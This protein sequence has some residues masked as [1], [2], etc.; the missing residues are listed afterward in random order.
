MEA[1]KKGILGRNTVD[2]M[3]SGTIFGAAAMVDGMID[4]ISD[5]LGEK[6]LCFIMWRYR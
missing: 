4:R 6:T 3:K 5:E 1:P 2:A